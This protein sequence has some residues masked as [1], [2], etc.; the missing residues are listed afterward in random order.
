MVDCIRDPASCSPVQVPTSHEHKYRQLV[1]GSLVS[2]QFQ[3]RQEDTTHAKSLM[4]LALV[5]P[6]GHAS[7]TVFDAGYLLELEEVNSK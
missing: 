6:K 3:T 1:R 5:L 2:V 7:E 4:H